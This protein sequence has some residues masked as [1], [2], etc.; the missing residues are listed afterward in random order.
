[1]APAPSAK[2]QYQVV[3]RLEDDD[4][5]TTVSSEEEIRLLGL[6]SDSDE[7]VIEEEDLF[8][9]LCEAPEEAKPKVRGGVARGRVRATVKKLTP[10]PCSRERITQA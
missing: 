5:S 6:G 8:K 3:Q 4:P 1:M 2:Q 9:A 10:R 7:P